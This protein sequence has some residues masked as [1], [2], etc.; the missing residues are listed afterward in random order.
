MVHAWV[1]DEYIHFA[2]IYITD[3]IFIVIPIKH[4]VNKNGEPTTPHKLAIGTKSSVSNLCVLFFLYVVLKATA[5]FDTKVL[6]LR[7]QS[8]KGFR[9]IFVEIP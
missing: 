7:H 1:S 3:H 9:V 5:Y 4:L 2:L 8:Q 6:N